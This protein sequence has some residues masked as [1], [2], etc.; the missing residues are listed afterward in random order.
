[1]SKIS[2]IL[3]KDSE[4]VEKLF[5]EKEEAMKALKTAEEEAETAAADAAK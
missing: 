4:K 1:M 5:N 2:F 3:K